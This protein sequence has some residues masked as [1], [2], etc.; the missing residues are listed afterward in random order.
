MTTVAVE[1]QK[2]IP[3]LR[4]R[5]SGRNKELFK[6]AKSNFIRG[7]SIRTNLKSPILREAIELGF[8]KDFAFKNHTQRKGLARSIRTL[9]NSYLFSISRL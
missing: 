8:N 5:R 1:Y 7:L 4:T 9:N 6:L 2:P 3:P